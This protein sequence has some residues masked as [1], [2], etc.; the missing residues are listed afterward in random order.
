MP[1][2][3]PF[4]EILAE[5]CRA[6]G[7]ELLP[8]KVSRTTSETDVVVRFQCSIRI[9]ARD[10]DTEPV[11]AARGGVRGLRAYVRKLFKLEDARQRFLPGM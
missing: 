6:E 10:Y 9:P 3:R 7:L 5:A 11:E 8:V 1:T 2:P 4:A